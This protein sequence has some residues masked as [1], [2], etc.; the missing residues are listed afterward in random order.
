MLLYFHTFSYIIHFLHR[1]AGWFFKKIQASRSFLALGHPAAV[2][3]FFVLKGHAPIWDDATDLEQS[4][5]CKHRLAYCSMY[6]KTYLERVRLINN[7][8]YDELFAK[9]KEGSGPN[10]KVF[11]KKWCAR[12]SYQ[13][14][15]FK[16]TTRVNNKKWYNWCKIVCWHQKKYAR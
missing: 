12:K 7:P 13:D 5:N 6:S 15:V 2:L 16:L 3:I 14:I 9:K 10:K 4:E 1:F 8:M 11:C